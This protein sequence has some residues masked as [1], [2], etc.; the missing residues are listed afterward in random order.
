MVNTHGAEKEE[1]LWFLP[2]KVLSNR[3][4]IKRKGAFR[5]RGFQSTLSDFL[6]FI[7]WADGDI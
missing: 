5:R 7:P 1:D 4:G 3:D 6:L 2:G